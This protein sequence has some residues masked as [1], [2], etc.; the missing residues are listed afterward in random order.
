[1]KKFILLF[2]VAIT[3]FSCMQEKEISSIN[4][5]NWSKRKITLN[6]KDSLEYGKSYLSIYSQ[7][8]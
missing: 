5:E 7:I 2:L 3:L 4:P 1:M 8:F 6:A